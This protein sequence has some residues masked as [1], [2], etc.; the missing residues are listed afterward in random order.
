MAA[1]YLL[2]LDAGSSGGRCLIVDER[3]KT[4][5]C[6]SEPWGYGSDPEAGPQSREFSADAFWS[7][8]SA[9]VRRALAEAGLAGSRITGVSATSQRQA[10]VF[11][12]AQG[13]EVYAGPNQD[14]RALS[15]GLALEAQHG[16]RLYASSGHWPAFLMAPARLLWLR[17]ERPD[18]FERLATVLT[19]ADWV[20]YRLTGERVGERALAGESGLID[21]TSASRDGEMWR[22]V[23]LGEGLLP[24]L[25]SAGGRVGGV[26]R[27]AAV[28]TGLAGGTLVYAGGPDSQCALAALGSWHE[29]EAAAVTG[30]SA[31]M[32][33]VTARPV[34]DPGRR[35]WAGLHL[36]QG[37]WVAESN[38][39][40]AGGVWQWWVDLLVGQGAEALADA[41]CLAG[42]ALPGSGDVLAFLGVAPLSACFLGARLGGLLFPVPLILR[43]PSR[44]SLLRAVLENVA[45][46]L[47]GGLE[48]LETVTGLSAAEVRLGGG[49]TRSAAFVRLLADVLGRPICV[50]GLPEVSALGAAMCAAVGAGLYS[51]FAEAQAMAP[52]LTRLEPDPAVVAD[53]QDFYRRWQSLDAALREAGA[54]TY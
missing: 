36:G 19:L 38:V 53:Y 49:M 34:I 2:A 45:F 52:P 35:T 8:L 39:G 29:G 12:D 7:I 54:G 6:A 10:L 33:M 40:E 25:V 18:L 27:A 50:G 16:G 20:L 14:V 22:L 17:E 48:T 23:G 46:A 28:E 51:S 11:L 32:Q 31:T 3:G 47:R 42:R 24:P 44:D 4:L 26:T 41:D 5:A 13:R 43:R 37:R 1:S 21:I 30:W 9:L 15:Q